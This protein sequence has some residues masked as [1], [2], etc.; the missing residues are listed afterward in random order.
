MYG[1][2]GTHHMDRQTDTTE[3]ITFPQTTRSTIE[4]C[5]YHVGLVLGVPVS[6]Y[7]HS[8][9]DKVIE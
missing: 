3:N 4:V 8:L 1:Y 5:S 2:M 7:E 9:T 6:Q